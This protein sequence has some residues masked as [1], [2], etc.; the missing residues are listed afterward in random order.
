MAE[1]YTGVKFST[2]FVEKKIPKNEKNSELI[3]WCNLFAEKKLL[4][5]KLKLKPNEGIRTK[6]HGNNRGK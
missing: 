4:I 3:K 2:I 6:M 5:A 1:N